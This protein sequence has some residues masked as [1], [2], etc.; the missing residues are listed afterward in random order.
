MNHH[1]LH[2]FYIYPFNCVRILA[3][4]GFSLNVMNFD[5]VLSAF[6]YI[7][8]LFFL[9]YLHL[10]SCFH[11]EGKKDYNDCLIL[12]FIRLKIHYVYF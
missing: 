4:F 2:T 12:R 5:L 11:Y 9:I 3:F 10:Q 1:Y 8:I 7:L 6:F